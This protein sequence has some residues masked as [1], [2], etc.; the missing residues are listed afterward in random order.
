MVSKKIR[1]LRNYFV[2]V[3]GGMKFKILN[4]D[5]SKNGTGRLPQRPV[6]LEKD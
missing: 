1:T 6:S 3:S 2:E 4:K 5:L